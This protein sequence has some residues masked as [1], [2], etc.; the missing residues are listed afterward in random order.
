MRGEP[1]TKVVL[2]IFRKTENRTFPVTIVREEIR[3]QSVRAKMIEP[4]YAWL[5]VSQ[6]QDRTVDDFVAQ[7]RRD[8]QAGPQPQGPGARPAQRPGRPARRRGG[9]L[10]RVPADRRDGGVR[11]TARSPNRKATFKAAPEFYH[12]PRR[13]PTRCAACPTRSRRCRWS[14]W[15]TKARPRPA[16]SSPARCRTTSAPPS[17]ARRPSARARCR[18]CA[19]CRPDT[20]LKIT[21]ARYYTPSGAS[22][23]AKGIVPDVMLDETAEGNLFAALRMREADLEKHLQQRPGRRAEGRGAREGPRR[24]AQEARRRAGQER[25]GAASRCPN[26][27]AAEDF[28]LTQAL[29]QPEGQA[30]AG[31]QDRGRAQG[32]GRDDQL[33][34]AGSPRRRP[35]PPRAFSFVRCRAR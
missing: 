20:A 17:W 3:T 19:S 15:S 33:S 4:G 12:A 6:F 25:R 2:T 18:P 10:G 30:G 8:L 27:A 7:A 35:C 14:C 29:N 21:T 24:S 26:S 34:P 1:N 22:I 28:Q 13:Q 31:Q 16:R 32:R 9:D 23:Q 5:R 11:P